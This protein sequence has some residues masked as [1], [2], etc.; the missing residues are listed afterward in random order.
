[1]VTSVE[2]ELRN[3]IRKLIMEAL[4]DGPGQRLPSLRQYSLQMG[5]SIP[6]LRQIFL[7]PDLAC[8][9]EGAPRRGFRTR[10]AQSLAPSP[11]LSPLV[12][13]ELGIRMA[14]ESGRYPSLQAL[15]KLNSL[16]NEWKTS[17]NTI[18]H[19]LRN[20]ESD[21]WLSR[22]KRRYIPG[23]SSNPNYRVDFSRTVLVI[24][25]S[26]DGWRSFLNKH[27][28][29]LCESLM[30]KIVEQGVKIRSVTISLDSFRSASDILRTVLDQEGKRL[31]GILL[32][33]SHESSV[34]FAKLVGWLCDRKKPVVHLD[35]RHWD[36]PNMTP[37]PW[38]F[39]I[40]QSEAKVSATA[41]QFLTQ[42][43]HHHIGFIEHSQQD[44]EIDRVTQL[45]NLLQKDSG[46]HL[47][48]SKKIQCEWEQMSTADF[49]LSL[50]T[51]EKQSKRVHHII[52][53]LEKGILRGGLSQLPK[54][55]LVPRYTDSRRAL[56][57][58]L[59]RSF[60][61]M[62]LEQKIE[63]IPPSVRG[64]FNRDF[65]EDYLLFGLRVL[66]ILLQVK[67]TVLVLARDR[68]IP[69]FVSRLESWGIGIGSDISLLS[70][71][72]NIETALY[73]VSTVDSGM[74]ALGN[75]LVHILLG[76]VQ[77]PVER[78]PRVLNA[79]PFVADKG[80]VAWLD[81]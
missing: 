56:A 74:G 38:F 59:Q 24:Q 11:P 19:A 55:Y 81:K 10:G 46:S 33:G 7:H 47:Y 72:N 23:L 71:D 6:T 41:I 58:L 60:E 29:P 80:S 32:V 79:K 45:N 73:P 34:T 20:L 66:P 76:A 15:P 5:V 35:R 54:K 9:V 42:R 51:A 27:T 13:V 16:A 14:I 4:P 65:L 22:E 31:V 3:K 68:T 25:I 52:G 53:I 64:C 50:Q 48:L 75:R 8:K 44:W 21:K 70:F 26:R 30:Q 67:C 49:L 57:A 62:T 69:H 39:T 1:M 18:V 28:R 61:G 78:G 2:T 63:S 36:Y 77:S 43:G 37:S 40:S 12:R 17:R